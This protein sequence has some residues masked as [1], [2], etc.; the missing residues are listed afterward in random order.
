[1]IE[2]GATHWNRGLYGAC[3][4]GHRRVVELMIEKGAD[5]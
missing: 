1:M 2:K 3:L 4:E 5:D